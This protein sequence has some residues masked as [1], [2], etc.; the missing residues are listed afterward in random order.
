[1][2][3]KVIRVKDELRSMY[4]GDLL[5]GEWF[6]FCNEQEPDLFRICCKISEDSA[7][8]FDNDSPAILQ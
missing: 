5:V 6:S 4:F 7:I 8:V 3:T 1:M 2:S